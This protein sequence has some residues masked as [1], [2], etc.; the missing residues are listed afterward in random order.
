MK[1]IVKKRGWIPLLCCCLLVQLVPKTTRAEGFV[2]LA[3]LKTQAQ[4]GFSGEFTAKGRTISFDLMPQLPDIDACPLVRVRLPNDLS[5][6]AP[7]LTGLEQAEPGFWQLVTKS[8]P[9]VM[10][11]ENAP[12][13]MRTGYEIYDQEG[14]QAEGNPMTGAEADA[15]YQQ[16]IAPILSAMGSFEIRL[17]SMEA[18]SRVYPNTSQ[19]FPPDIYQILDR[20]KPLTQMGYYVLVYEQVFCGLPLLGSPPFVYPEKQTAS[21]HRPR[22]EASGLVASPQDYVLSLGLAAFDSM[23]SAD[24][25]LAPFEKVKAAFLELFQAGYAYEIYGLRFG[26]LLMH[27][28]DNLGETFLLLP[29]WELRGHF[30]ENP[31][32][33]F[34]NQT[35]QEK[36]YYRRGG[37]MTLY[38]NAQTAQFLDPLDQRPKRGIASPLFWDK[39][40]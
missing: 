24:L 35:E 29:V 36:A 7:A 20:S 30:V 6:S 39:L 34:P 19:S 33:P 17:R 31:A 5:T 38:L 28:P 25:P 26:S 16:T 23:P 12:K 32:F 4:Q 40:P 3:E 8:A 13:G 15:L 18:T 11:P 9:D 2:S 22:G 10:F 14:A 1:R 27:D 21:L 37:G